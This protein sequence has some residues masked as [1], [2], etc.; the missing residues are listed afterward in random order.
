MNH[1]NNEI[2]SVNGTEYRGLTSTFLSSVSNGDTVFLI[3]EHHNSHDKNAIKV[4]ISNTHVGYIPKSISNERLAH[5]L[6]SERKYNAKIHA[7]NL[8]NSK[9]TFKILLTTYPKKRPKV[10]RTKVTT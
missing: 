2:L 7:I 9:S 5:I 1:F 3:R 8:C 6:D 4:I 10:S